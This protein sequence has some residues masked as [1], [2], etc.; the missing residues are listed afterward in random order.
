MYQRI[1]I[2]CHKMVDVDYTPTSDP[3]EDFYKAPAPEGWSLLTYRLG[4]EA[5]WV[6]SPDCELKVFRNPRDYFRG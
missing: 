4:S 5:G 2:C 1:C 3:V 6:C